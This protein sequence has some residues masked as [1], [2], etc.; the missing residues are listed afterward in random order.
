MSSRDGQYRLV[1]RPSDGNPKRNRG[2]A[3]EKELPGDE[4][5]PQHLRN[6]NNA[7]LERTLSTM[8]MTID[9]KSV[10]EVPRTCQY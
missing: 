7:R 5:L 9:L 2:P 6:G 4:D 3:R 10:C 1:D 8:Y